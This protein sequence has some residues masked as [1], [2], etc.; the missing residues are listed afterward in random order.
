MLL[1]LSAVMLMSCQDKPKQEEMTTEE[2]T[3]TAG[4]PDFGMKDVNGSQISIKEEIKKNKITIL[5]FWASWCG[6][7]MAEAPKMVELY[8]QFHEKGLGIIGISLDEKEDAWKGAIERLNMNWTHVTDLK[9]WN[10]E[11]AQYFNVNGIPYTKVV[12][13]NG[14]VLASGLRAAELKSFLEANL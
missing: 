7:C 5:D 9:G 13:A 3:E 8:N 2:T 4:I 6:P 10:N 1:V 14:E 12:N 11:A